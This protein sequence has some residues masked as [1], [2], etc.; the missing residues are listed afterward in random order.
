M[1]IRLLLCSLLLAAV[2]YADGPPLLTSVLPTEI[3]EV[4]KPFELQLEV[5][6]KAP[7]SVQL[8]DDSIEQADG[9]EIVG[10]RLIGPVPLAPLAKEDA[11][12]SSRFQTTL[13][14]VL[15]TA[16]P[17]SRTLPS[18]K[19]QVT[20]DE[21]VFS[22]ASE[23]ATVDVQGIVPEDFDPTEFRQLK[24]LAEI[25]T[26]KTPKRISAWVAAIVVGLIGGLLFFWRRSKNSDAAIRQRWISEIDS[27]ETDVRNRK[28]GLPEAHDE[29]C[30]RIRQWIQSSTRIPATSLPTDQLVNQLRSRSWPEPMLDR[31][32]KMLARND[33]LKF[34]DG[35][36]PTEH[37]STVFDDA[38]W[39]IANPTIAQLRERN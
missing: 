12:P 13:V 19:L 34:A 36:T 30:H 21:Q 14:L 37:A 35:A 11:N 33:Q 10:T 2:S 3:I 28:S 20:I 15:E 39:M 16:R 23:A 1:L 22:L 18:F 38:R 25:E 24:P 5:V 27:L 6:S 17:G 29:T 7:A 31:L 8:I 4:A 26:T 32:S 9:F